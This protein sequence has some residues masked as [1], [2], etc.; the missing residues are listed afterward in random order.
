MSAARSVAY[1]NVQ[2]IRS[3][4]AAGENIA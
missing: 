2:R 4:I 1:A 3:A